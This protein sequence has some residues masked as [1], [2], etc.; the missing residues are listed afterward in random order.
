MLNNNPAPHIHPIHELLANRWSPV[1]FQNKKGEME[2]INSLLEA[3]RWAPSS[4]NEQPWQYIIGFHGDDTFHKLSDCL[5]PGNSWAKSAP[6][7]MLSV[8]K[9]FFGYNNK[10][11]RHHLHDTGA[12][13]A[14]MALEATNQNI[15]IHQMEGFSIEK[16]TQYFNIPENYVTGSMI[17][18]GYPVEDKNNLP[19][20]LKKRD[21]SPRT[22]KPFEEMI[23][24][25]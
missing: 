22:R 4:Y 1:G 6:V 10:L 21:Q 24:K 14:Y 15:A 8:I 25:V 20:D 11:N 16:A 7:L 13:S 19:E 2:K 23:W 3:A 18:I 17:A 12:A 5:T 9:T